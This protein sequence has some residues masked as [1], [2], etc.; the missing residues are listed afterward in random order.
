[1]RIGDSE[2]LDLVDHIYLEDSLE[3]HF[4]IPKCQ[5]PEVQGRMIFLG[6][7]MRGDSG[8]VHLRA[9]KVGHPALSQECPVLCH[10]GSDKPKFRKWADW[11]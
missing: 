4:I 9:S 11:E 5:H 10:S 8:R 2:W 3:R 6:E 7:W 1:M